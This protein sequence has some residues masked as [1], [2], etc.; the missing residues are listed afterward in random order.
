MV[1]SCGITISQES[2]KD[3]TSLEPGIKPNIYKEG[4]GEKNRWGID[5]HFFG[6]SVHY[7]GRITDRFFLGGEIGLLPDILDWVLLAGKN[8]TK[9]NTIWSDDRSE[10]NFNQFGQIFFIHL[11]GRWAPKNKWVEFDA[12]LRRA[13]FIYSVPH[14]DRID[15]SVFNGGYI[16]PSIGHKRF[17]IGARLDFGSMS[18]DY[19]DVNE[20]VVMCTPFVRINF[21]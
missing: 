16:K 7:A 13:R 3:S 4:K 20:F 2:I 11:F 1:F 21:K 10:E 12:G 19:G 5:F 15:S 8:F 17:K 6:T 18:L 9:E 14:E